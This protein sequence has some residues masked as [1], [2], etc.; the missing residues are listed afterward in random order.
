[1]GETE[2]NNNKYDCSQIMT[3]APGSS[4]T[5]DIC[6]LDGRGIDTG[7]RKYL[8]FSVA[9]LN[10]SGFHAIQFTSPDAIK[11]DSLVFSRVG[12]NVNWA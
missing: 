1:M 9:C 4:A 11:L 12:R 8:L 7:L 3:V 5:V 6:V 2:T 10:V